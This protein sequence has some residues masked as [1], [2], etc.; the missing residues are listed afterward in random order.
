MKVTDV[1]ARV[2]DLDDRLNL[3][4]FGRIRRTHALKTFLEKLVTVIRE[5]MFTV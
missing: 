1:A 2:G 5:K 4:N 3:W